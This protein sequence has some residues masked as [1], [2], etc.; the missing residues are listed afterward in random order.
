[1]DKKKREGGAR[2]KKEKGDRETTVTIPY[3]KGV[4]EAISC[5]SITV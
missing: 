4:L 5:S 1:M 3:I 2:N